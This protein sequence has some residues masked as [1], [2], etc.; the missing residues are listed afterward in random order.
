MLR[1]MVMAPHPPALA[2][3]RMGALPGSVTP[4]SS[5]W[6]SPHASLVLRRHW[7]GTPSGVA[8]AAAASAE[9]YAVEPAAPD[10]PSVAPVEGAEAAR[11]ADGGRSRLV[12]CGLWLARRRLV[13][14]VVGPGDEARR[15]IRAVLTDDARFGLVEYLAAAGAELVATEAL[16]RMDLMPVQAARRGLVVWTV[17]DALVA[18]LLRAAAIRDPARAAALLARLP[19]IPLLR[20]SVRRL[21]LP[22]RRQLPLL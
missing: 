11:T 13:A 5:L 20:S 12:T 15:V 4:G 9:W 6:P 7:T 21:V 10:L 14:A 16:A 18:A 1:R 19:V 22:D 17:G 8:L 2:T 3:R